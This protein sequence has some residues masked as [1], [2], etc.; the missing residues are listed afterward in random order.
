MRKNLPLYWEI[1]DLEDLSDKEIEIY[2]RKI[3][4]IKNSK[5]LY[6]IYSIIIFG[7]YLETKKINKMPFSG[8]NTEID[9]KT[10]FSCSINQIPH[11]VKSVV[12]KFVKFILE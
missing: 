2:I 10:G 12:A 4:T 9:N 3:L 1:S 6:Y 11:S 8:K 5:I 7:N